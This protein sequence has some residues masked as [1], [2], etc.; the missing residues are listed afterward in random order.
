M[1]RK[2]LNSRFTLTKDKAV[3]HVFSEVMPIGHTITRHRKHR[4]GRGIAPHI[5]NLCVTWGRMANATTRLMYH[6]GRTHSTDCNGSWVGPMARRDVYGKKEI[7]CPGPTALSRFPDVMP[8]RLANTY[9]LTWYNIL[10]GLR[11]HQHRCGK[12]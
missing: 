2:K 9:Q 3:F 5:L 4:R 1:L 12:L 6:R 7:S 11:L 8:S 10:E